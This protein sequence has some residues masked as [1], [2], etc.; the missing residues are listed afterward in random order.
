MSSQRKKLDRPRVANPCPSSWD[1]MKVSG[2]DEG[3]RF[4]GECQR[5]VFDFAQMTSRQIHAHLQASRGRL[6]AR[7]TYSGGWLQVLSTSPQLEALRPLRTPPRPSPL[8]AS[9][10]TAWLGVGAA[11][12]QPSVQGGRVALRSH[13]YGEDALADLARDSG[14]EPDRVME[15]LVATAENP[16][17]RKEATGEIS[18]ALQ[19]LEDFLEEA[20]AHEEQ[21]FETLRLDLERA[22]AE[23]VASGEPPRTAR[24]GAS[25]TERQKHR[26]TRALQEA[27]SLDEGSIGLLE[28]V[29]LWDPEAATSWFAHRLRNDEA[30]SS[31]QAH[32]WL[33]EELA[34][35]LGDEEVIAMAE[36]NLERT[37][38]IEGYGPGEEDAELER[39]RSDARAQRRD[40][41]DRLATAIGRRQITLDPEW[42]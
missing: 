14:S 12:A 5:E 3:R 39:L 35:A 21:T 10:V 1:R 25:L 36:S 42:F 7:L 13:V 17:T 40:L 26:L 8:A 24:L 31:S 27:E 6:C 11:Q 16:Q 41:Y 23:S 18:H 20:E 22:T 33:L 38:E 19:D 30:E 37:A 9:P 32:L 29:S 28:L 4:C 34:D 2:S 15:W